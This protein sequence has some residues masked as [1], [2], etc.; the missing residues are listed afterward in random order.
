MKRWSDKKFMRTGIILLLVIGC[1]VASFGLTFHFFGQS[2]VVP[3][4]SRQ[5]GFWALAPLAVIDRIYTLLTEQR[6]YWYPIPMFLVLWVSYSIISGAI[7]LWMLNR[8]GK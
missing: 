7:A 1:A 2:D 6:L 8:R 4:P 5:F 3:A